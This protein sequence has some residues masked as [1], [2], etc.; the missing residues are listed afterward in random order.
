MDTTFQDIRSLLQHVVAAIEPSI[1][2]F[3]HAPSAQIANFYS[4]Q[5]PRH[6]VCEKCE[7]KLS[8]VACSDPGKWKDAKHGGASGSKTNPN[9]EDAH[10]RQLNQNKLLGKNK[11]YECTISYKGGGDA[12]PTFCEYVHICCITTPAQFCA[13]RNWCQVQDMQVIAASGGH[14]LSEMRL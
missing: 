10:G 7:K 3:L 9:K 4:K 6:M 1:T 2:A 12:I 5:T 13:I 14:L 8:K 11:R